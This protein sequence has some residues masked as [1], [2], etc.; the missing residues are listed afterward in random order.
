MKSLKV[1]EIIIFPET[2]MKKRYKYPLIALSMAFAAAAF[3]F[4]E[5]AYVG[6]QQGRLIEARKDRNHLSAKAVQ[7]LSDRVIVPRTTSILF[8]R[9]ADRLSYVSASHEIKLRNAAND[10][11]SQAGRNDSMCMVSEAFRNLAKQA[12]EIDFGK[13]LEELD[14]LNN[15]SVPQSFPARKPD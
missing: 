13:I 15:A 14:E 9:Y 2:D 11:G 1:R 5:A 4:G 7:C 10:I 3:G 6:I 8:G 12:K